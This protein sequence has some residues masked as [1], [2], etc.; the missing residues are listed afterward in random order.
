[1]PIAAEFAFLAA[2]AAAA[3]FGT[4]AAFEAMTAAE[5]ASLYGGMEFGT[6]ALF[7]GASEFGTAGLLGELA[8]NQ[9]I[10]EALGASGAGGV[11]PAALSKA[12]M[13]ADVLAGG[14]GAGEAG[15]NAAQV[16]QQQAKAAELANSGLVNPV[17]ASRSIPDMGNASGVQ[18]GFGRTGI[19]APGLTPDQLAGPNQYSMN[20]GLNFSSPMSATPITPAPTSTGF[21]KGVDDAMAWA[22][23]NPFSA[24]SMAMNALT[25]LGGKQKQGQL[26][27]D[28]Y[29]GG[30]LQNYKMSPNFQGRFANPQD[31]QYTP[32]VYNMAEGGIAQI[33]GGGSIEAMSNAN[34][35]GAN[36]GYPMANIQPGAYATPYQQ[37]IPRNVITDSADTGVNP[38]NGEM[39]FSGGGKTPKPKEH[40]DVGIIF[41]TDPDTRSLDAL[42]AAQVRQAKVNKRAN[43]QL[44]GIKR[45]TPMGQLNMVPVTMKANP[46]APDTTEAAQGGIMS[47]GGYAAGGNPRLLKGPGDGMS[48][49]IP[50]T[51]AGKQPA[52]L[53]DGEFVVPAD[54]VS[55]LGNG[56]TE[57]GAKKLHQMMNNVRKARTGNPKQGKQIVAEKYLPSRK[58]A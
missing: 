45:P 41:D 31:Y 56:S 54:V 52:R 47:L 40:P 24:G 55:H 13:A 50:A 5:A 26:G 43:M 51:I 3:E 11:S 30:I 57:A 23:K 34:A 20:Q 35:V 21:M 33:A 46:S 14:A 9:G 37:P 49:N 16:A 18:Q 19:K 2:D 28:P 53:A 38:M 15:I 36:T 22:K 58:R 29:K 10:L 44:P 39:R 12:E 17:E 32:K 8:T 27:E 25:L 48:D 42:T 6:E 1:M 4:A 7:S